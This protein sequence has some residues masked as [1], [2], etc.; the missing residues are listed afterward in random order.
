MR[1]T[2]PVDISITNERTKHTF[3][4]R[5]IGLDQVVVT[6]FSFWKQEIIS[7][8]ESQKMITMLYA[9][10]V[11]RKD[12]EAMEELDKG[13]KNSAKIIAKDILGS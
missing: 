4:F 13:L 1:L 9:A 6:L 5:N 8:A 2:N 7:L 3:I 11:S 10:A 12:V